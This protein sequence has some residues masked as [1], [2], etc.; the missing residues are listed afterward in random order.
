M[1]FWQLMY[2]HCLDICSRRCSFSGQC[3]YN[4]LFFELADAFQLLCHVNCIYILPFLGLEDTSNGNFVSTSHIFDNVR[5][6][7]IEIVHPQLALPMTCRYS[8]AKL[9]IRNSRKSIVADIPIK[10]VFST[11]S[12]YSLQI[13]PTKVLLFNSSN[14]R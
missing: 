11:C 9:C 2:L 12:F 8:P 1:F 3:I 13:L 14:T 5:M 7:L 4:L 6:L 10:I